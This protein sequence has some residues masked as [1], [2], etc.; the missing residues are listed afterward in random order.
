MTSKSQLGDVLQKRKSA[1]LWQLKTFSQKTGAHLT[2]LAGFAKLHEA[3]EHWVLAHG[4]TNRPITVMEKTT[5]GTLER[6]VIIR[7]E[8]L[9]KIKTD[10]HDFWF[11]SLCA[12]IDMAIFKTKKH[13]GQETCWRES[14]FYFD[15]ILNE[16]LESLPFESLSKMGYAMYWI[17]QEEMNSRLVEISQCLDDHATAQQIALMAKAL[18]LVRQANT[19]TLKIRK[20]NHATE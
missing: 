1:F 3:S 2:G 5:L 4:V 13:F 6:F 18:R 11:E 16:N 12:I 15:G 19:G 7:E 14:N 9:R 10:A 20:F 8:S 17:D